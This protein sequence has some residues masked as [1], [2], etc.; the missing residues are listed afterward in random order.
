M[1]GPAAA[2]APLSNNN[3]LFVSEDITPRVPAA[4]E[5]QVAQA[6]LATIPCEM[7]L[8]A[9]VDLIRDQAG[10]PVLLELELTEPSLFFAQ[11]PGAAERLAQAVTE[12][13]IPLHF[14]T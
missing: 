10:A 12:H 5:L 11:A 8:Y 7:P 3:G 4:D 2:A 6:V 13:L 1:L 14:R 9:R